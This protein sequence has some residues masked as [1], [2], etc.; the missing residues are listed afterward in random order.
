LSGARL[1]GVDA[2]REAQLLF[3]VIDTISAGLDLNRMLQGVATLVTETTATDV[4]FVHLLDEK[5]RALRL[6]GATPPFDGLAG[7]IELAVGEG[8]SGWVAEHGEPVVILDD[9]AADPR[10]LYIPALRGE[11]FTSMVSVPIV[12]PLGHLVGV[13]NVHTRARREFSGAD[14]ELLRTVAGLVAGAI[15]NARLHRRLAEREEA[16]ESFAER[17]VEWQERESRRLAGEIHDG[18][19][20]R[21]VSLFFHLSAAADVIG[22][23]PALAAEQIGRAQELAAAA[24]DETRSAIAGLRPPVLDDL[25]LA[26]S[27]DS[28]G[29]SFPGLDVRVDAAELRMAGHVETAVYRTAQEALQNVAKHASAQSVR[30]RLSHHAERVLLEISDDGA[31]F[32]P[33]LQRAASERRSGVPSPTGLGL[34]GMRERAELLGGTLELISA[35]GRG[36]TVRL[37]V[38]FT[39]PAYPGTAHSGIPGWPAHPPG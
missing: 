30:I 8:V 22:A 6:H 21:I 20:Q 9:K 2:D 14:V 33:E 7:Q 15:E 23:D 16:L 37:A 12:T 13:L 5:G 3:R 28:L 36:T 4:C 26:A 17:I 25:G 29:H 11:E 31:G 19:S 27:L 38:P 32:D 24:L 35:P 39:P 1:N 18:I 34:S 10:Y